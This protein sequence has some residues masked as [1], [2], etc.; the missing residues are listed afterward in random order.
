M[1]IE[2]L[3]RELLDL[4]KEQQVERA[5]ALHRSLPNELDEVW[6][7]TFG[8]GSLFDA[9]TRTTICGQVHQALAEELKSTVARPGFRIVEV[10]GGDGKMWSR[11][12]EGHE[13]GEI[14]VVDPVAEAIDRVRERVPE[15]V[16]VEGR[17]GLVQDVELPPSDAL[18]ISLTLHHVA[19]RDAAERAAYGLEGPGKQEVL[20]AIGRCLRPRDG[21]ALLMEASVH[22]E[23]DLAPGDPVLR[24]NLLDSYVRRCTRSILLDVE[25]EPDKALLHAYRGLIRHWF[26]GQVAMA[27][28]PR[29][30]RDVY[31]LRVDQW[32]DVIARSGLHTSLPR[33]VDDHALFHLYRLRSK[34]G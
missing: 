29:P 17:V 3:I 16:H 25:S 18:V 9:W 28:L 20:E 1:P 8:P 30:K 2:D 10:G 34:N 33:C 22:C 31:E 27:D 4:P 19:G 6:N 14:V 21:F 7:T 15:G 12:F 26:L 5:L 24:D 32:L 11:V 23:L 13:Q